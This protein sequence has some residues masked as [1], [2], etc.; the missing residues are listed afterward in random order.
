MQQQQKIEKKTEKNSRQSG[1][2][3]L[4]KPQKADRQETFGLRL[5][6]VVAIH[7]WVIRL[8]MERKNVCFDYP[9]FFFFW[10]Y[11]FRK[12]QAIKSVKIHTF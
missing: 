9:I 12:Y 4:H 8:N 3:W 10:V 7:L 2:Y 1:K 5:A 6:N 11:K